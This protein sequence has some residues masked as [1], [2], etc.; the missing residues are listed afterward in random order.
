MTLLQFHTRALP[1]LTNIMLRLWVITSFEYV[2]QPFRQTLFRLWI[3][4][5]HWMLE[6]TA[7]RWSVSYRWMECPRVAWTFVQKSQRPPRFVRNPIDSVTSHKTGSSFSGI[8]L[9]LSPDMN[10]FLLNNGLV[11]QTPQTLQLGGLWTN[12]LVITVLRIRLARP[13]TRVWSMNVKPQAGTLSLLLVERC[14]L[15]VVW[16]HV[17]RRC[18]NSRWRYFREKRL[19]PC[20]IRTLW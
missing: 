13:C 17:E 19:Y 7:G 11:S 3:I 9:L 1:D 15:I 14:C 10:L 18:L 4:M 16:K 6:R 12:V 20:K 2:C 5:Q 8:I